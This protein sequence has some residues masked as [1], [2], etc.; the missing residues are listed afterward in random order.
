MKKTLTAFAVAAALLLAAGCGSDAG[1][2]EAPAD[3]SSS[4]TQSSQTAPLEDWSFLEPLGLAGLGVAEVVQG[5]ETTAADREA[6]VVGSVR[7]DHIIFSTPAGEHTMPI[8]ENDFY[9]SVAPFIEKT[10]ECFYHNLATC[11]GEL[12]GEDLQV[13]ITSAD[14]QVLIDDTVTT[15]Q[16][17]FAG[18]WL[19][20]DMEGTI[21]VS[22]DGKSVTAPIGTGPD[23]PTCITTLQ[24]T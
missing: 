24:L 14:G 1:D 18:F 10:H 2:G 16:N 23:D 20:R 9:M 15:Y 22:Y 7:Y 13:K 5:L 17:G 12:V 21:E 3:A 19:P 8:P 6:G 4:T 11:Q